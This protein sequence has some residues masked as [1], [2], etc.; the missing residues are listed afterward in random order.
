MTTSAFDFDTRHD[1]SGT[2]CTKWEKRTNAEKAAG[3]LPMWIADMDFR[4]A[5]CIT[6]ALRRAV[7]H[8]IYGYT[9]ATDGYLEAVQG[10]MLRRHDW[11]IERDWI[12]YQNGVVPALSVAMRAFLE[13]GDRVLLQPPCY[14]PFYSMVRENGFEPLLN[15]LLRGEDGQYRIDFDDLRAKAREP[16]VRMLI[17]CSPHNP[18]GR[19]F[20][21]DE[22][23]EVAEICRANDMLVISDEIHFDFALKG[24]HT[25]FH[26]AAPEM[27]DRSIVCTAPSKTFNIAG[28]QISNIIIPSPAL[29]ALYKKRQYADGY[30]NPPYFGREAVIAAYTHGDAWL[31]AL[32]TYLRG[33]FAMLSGWF[34]ENLPAVRLTQAESTYL[35]WTDWRAL[36]LS[37]EE[38]RRFL[39]EEA[40]VYF[41]DGASFSADCGGFLRINL[42]LPHEVLQ[43]A[44]ERILAALRLHGK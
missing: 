25:V 24:R 32:L 2:G 1:R 28:L 17:L 11:T 20:S 10:W 14:P 13:P 21:A 16:R 41:N 22:L 36:G 43:E 38:L 8:G 27:M 34:Q 23:R 9:E 31:D 44:L 40:R 37:P 39:R 19:V 12:V 30:E 29:R 33:N 26:K 5:P 15:P 18:T 7:E 4:T 6:E 35:A 42:A 3:V